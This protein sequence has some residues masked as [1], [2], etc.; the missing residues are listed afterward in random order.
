MAILGFM[1]VLAVL[2]YPLVS[3]SRMAARLSETV[4]EQA[5]LEAVAADE[6]LAALQRLAD[7]DDLQVDH[8]D[9]PWAQPL[10]RRRPDGVT[11]RVT[12]ED[13]GRRFDV[14]NL[15]SPRAAEG[16]GADEIL[17]A[18]LP[19][20]GSWSG[21]DRTAALRDWMDDDREGNWEDAYYEEQ[22]LA[23]ACPNRPLATAQEWRWV[24]GWGE[25]WEVP[26]PA[27]A[28]PVPPGAPP[29]IRLGDLLT[30]IPGEHRT[31]EPV[32]LNTAPEELLRA[33]LGEAQRPIVRGILALR[34]AAPLRSHENIAILL[35][36][37]QFDRLRPY[38]SVRSRHF[39][40]TATAASER[41]A[42]RVEALVRRE[43]G[44]EIRIL[45]WTVGVA[46]DDRPESLL[47]AD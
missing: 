15:S 11:V 30:W 40:V 8:A 19:P 27:T 14:N 4:A 2:A 26:A 22:K 1:A 9:E 16:G 43:G 29:S 18:L 39:R 23:M 31:P 13:E 46:P 37:L 20:S 6:A 10:A 32:N 12:T 34:A 25:G 38:V 17:A 35:D 47:A 36:P 33:L 42:L 5:R 41:L 3:D 44:G 28:D 24:A 45:H 21:R 7:D